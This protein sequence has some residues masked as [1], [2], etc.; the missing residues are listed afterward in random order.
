MKDDD[1]AKPLDELMQPG[2]TLMVGTGP[3]AGA[4]LR[5]LTVARVQGDVIDILVDGSAE[6]ALAY[7]DGDP[8]LAVQSDNRE[9]VWAWIRGTGMLTADQALIDE[10]W[11]P[12]AAAYFEQGRETPD[13]TV[14]RIQADD[15]RY[16]S[17]PSGRLGSLI[18]TIKA[19][20][21]DPEQSGEHGDVR[22]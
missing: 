12:F 5:P 10:L 3:D 18:S 16:W 1:P 22:V 15:G 9:N 19:K 11:N 21:G 8:V 13:I 20:F 6:W 4:E 17:S 7:R 2:A 14:L